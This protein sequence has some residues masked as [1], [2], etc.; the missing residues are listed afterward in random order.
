MSHHAAPEM[1]LTMA[2]PDSHSDFGCNSFSRTNPGATPK[3]CRAYQTI[4]THLDSSARPDGTFHSSFR[5]TTHNHQ[6]I[7]CRHRNSTSWLLQRGRRIPTQLR[8]AIDRFY[9]SVSISS[10]RTS[11]RHSTR[12]SQREDYLPP[13]SLN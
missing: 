13:N 11:P 1:F 12:H 10:R 8:S 6:V 9:Q 4:P 5:N 2:P 3:H 7:S